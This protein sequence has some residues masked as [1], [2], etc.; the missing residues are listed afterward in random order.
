MGSKRPTLRVAPAW[1]RPA[2]PGLD[3]GGTRN[4]AVRA[5][6]SAVRGVDRLFERHPHRRMFGIVTAVVE[7]DGALYFVP[8]Y[9]AHR[10]VARSIL[11]Q[12][13]VEPRLHRLVE[14]LMARRPGSMIHAGTF[15]GD[16]L[17][18]FS[19]KTAGVVYAF[20]PVI[21][22]YLLARAVMDENDLRNVMLVHAGL[23]AGPG[24][25]RIET[26]G[27]LRHRGGSCKV[28][29]DPA[30]RTF[31]LQPITLLSIDQFAIEDL[32]LIQLDVE[33]YELPVLQ[34]AVETIERQQPVIVIEDDRRNCSELLNELGYLKVARI[35][36]DHLYLT[37][38]D[39]ADFPD[40]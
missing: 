10:P 31:R 26:R 21:E 2:H 24:L 35:G 12:T 16:M 18:S 6:A 32:S 39:A 1:L 30:T 25:A 34:G 7:F 13:Y 19:R 33:G 40:L 5:A 15:F 38:S 27:P 29:T 22:N 8:R 20:E 36:R 23:G 11:R 28:I 17:P 4:A 14:T 9:G 37:E 3:S